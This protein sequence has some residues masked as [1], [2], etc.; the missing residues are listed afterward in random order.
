MKPQ[1]LLT[2]KVFYFF[3]FTALGVYA[4]FI[5]LYYQKRGLDL[6]QIG[7]LL[8]LPGITQIV[9]GPLW[10]LLADALHLHRKLLPL[11][12]IGTIIPITLIG[13][14]DS[15][16]PIL[17][18][19][20]CSAIFSVPIAA[21][22]DTATLTLLGERREQYG[23]QRVW[24]AIGWGLSSII[25]GVIV[26]Q[27]GL[28]IMFWIFP[29]VGCGAVLA[30]L[31]LPG[32]EL[33]DSHVLGTAR[34]LLRDT[35][36]IRFLFCSLLIGCSASLMHGFLSIYLAQ[37]G[38]GTDQIGL[39]YTIASISEMPVMALAPLVLRRWGARPLLVC[40]GLAYALRLTIYILAPSPEW[41]LGAQL[42]H[43]FCFAAM[44]TA[45]V[46]EA[47]RLALP[48][49][50]ATAQS[51]FSTALFGVAVVIANTI[52]GVIYQNM[53]STV[54]FASAA[55]LALIGAVGFMLP[56]EER[57]PVSIAVG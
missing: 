54:L 37:L 34:S 15:F 43:G 31:R 35:R 41:A 19:A 44:W 7:L 46:H 24:G 18:L 26:R 57:K 14:L 48:G 12:I 9:A 23:A 56:F 27:F 40:A 28:G 32:A 45:G 36:W 47:Q 52:G 21:L 2:P 8:A 38:A 4:P 22:S 50:A 42:L 53:G 29:V 55:V 10:G 13:V 17:L 5:T 3:W 1:S 25:S 11:V 16:W 30:S 20:A 33:V 49:L 51:L 6:S 39:A